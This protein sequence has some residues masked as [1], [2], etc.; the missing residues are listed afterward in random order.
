MVVVLDLHTRLPPSPPLA[1][2][3]SALPVASRPPVHCFRASPLPFVPWGRARKDCD[4]SREYMP[5]AT[6]R[7][8]Y[9]RPSRAVPPCLTRTR[10]RQKRLP[11]A[12][13]LNHSA[14]SAGIDLPPF[15]TS[16]DPSCA[17]MLRL[18]ARR[19]KTKTRDPRLRSAPLSIS[20]Q[21]ALALM[22]LRSAAAAADDMIRAPPRAITAASIPPA[23]ASRHQ[24]RGVVVP[25]PSFFR[26]ASLYSPVPLLPSPLPLLALPLPLLSE[27]IVNSPDTGVRL[28]ITSMAGRTYLVHLCPTC[29]VYVLDRTTGPTPRCA[30]STWAVPCGAVEG[31]PGTRAALAVSGGRGGNVVA[32]G[33]TAVR[34]AYT[35]AGVRAWACA[36]GTASQRVCAAAAQMVDGGV[37]QRSRCAGGATASGM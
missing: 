29:C 21:L 14:S 37:E 22:Q 19:M 31:G 34:E 25:L 5:R 28:F 33:R 8:G 26:E 10:T 30:R 17:C 4:M 11:I 2:V 35:D 7:H 1:D 9:T 20:V 32:L 12:R 16:L 6:P 23:P 27:P 18:V 13:Y 15:A 36:G 3:A 24:A